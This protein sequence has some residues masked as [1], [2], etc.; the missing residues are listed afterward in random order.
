MSARVTQSMTNSQLLLSLNR[1]LKQTNVYMNQL[2][3]GRTI[4]KPS[5]DPTGITYS[6][7]Y[8][9]ELAANDQ[10]QEN[11]DSAYSFLEYADAQIGQANDIMQRVR[12]LTVEA[13]NGTNPD[14][15]L[16]SIKDEVEVL[17]EQLMT[18]GNST[19]NGKYIFNGQTTDQKPYSED[20]LF[21][22]GTDN[23]TV[24]Y[25]VGAGVTIDIGITGNEVFGDP[26]DTGSNDYVFK[27]MDDLSTALQN[28]DQTAMESILGRIDSRINKMLNARSEVG[29]KA[30]R[31]E[32]VQDRLESLGTNLQNLQSKTEDADI[33]EV[34]TN[35]KTSENVYQAS[36]AT[37][38]RIIQQSLVDY[39][40]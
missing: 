4:N 26:T 7:R 12:E 39:L 8:R 34:I 17:R 11:A 2:S 6:L 10:Y 31:V 35:L 21:T 36:L 40:D 28:N 20:T 30:N 1:N 13:S 23:R 22:Q 19:M 18:I 9:S 24:E 33:S 25:S 14:T 5:D 38:A 3:T 16:Q 32:L 15:S 37:G 29:A 27:I